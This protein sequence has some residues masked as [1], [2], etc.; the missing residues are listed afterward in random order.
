[1]EKLSCK[2]TDLLLKFEVISKENYSI[3]KY[4][5]LTGL[6][7]SLWILF[8][9]ITAFILDMVDESILFFILFLNLRSYVGGIHLKLYYHCFALSTTIHWIILL[10]TKYSSMQLHIK[11]VIIVISN[12]ILLF[13]KPV[14]NSNRKVDMEEN[15]LFE[16]KKI[17]NILIVFIMS[18]IF[19][20]LHLN[21][22]VS[23][24]AYTLFFIAI[25]TLLGS[26]MNQIQK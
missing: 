10:F 13:F 20:F 11:M 9:V 7:L 3:Y 17:R 4:G 24:T 15:I 19:Y 26:V 5:F 16:T 6:E 18:L 8:C 12:C 22:Y 14:D 25:S 2:L 1:M 21:T 23:L